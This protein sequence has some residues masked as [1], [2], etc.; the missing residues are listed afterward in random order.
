MKMRKLKDGIFNSFTIISAVIVTLLLFMIF[1]FV[2]IRGAHLINIRLLLND[3]HAKNYVVYIEDS[4]NQTF[5]IIETEDN[6]YFVPNYGISLSESKDL[7]GNAIIEVQYVSPDSPLKYLELINGETIEFTKGMSIQRIAFINEPS[8]QRSNGAQEM[9]IAL[10]NDESTLREISFSIPGGGIR[11]PLISTI[12]LI[13][14]TLFIVIPFGILSALYLNEY[15]PKNKITNTLRRFIETLSGVPSI[16]FGLVGL[17]IFVPFTTMVTKASGANLIAGALTLSAIL[18]PIVIRTTEEGFKMVPNEHRHVSLALG[19]NTFQT[20]IFIVVP[21]SLPNILTTIFLSIGRIIGESAALI[22]VLGT[23][24][25][26][27][28]SIYERTPS[29]AV[30]IWSLMTREPANVELASAIAIIILVVVLLLNIFIKASVTLL[31]RRTNDDG[32]I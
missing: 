10:N 3:F 24:I 15:A 20:S 17:S 7:A 13:G 5:D 29:L 2:I 18:L 6:E 12:Y 9:A 32:N 8:V 4:F 16:V 21:G 23:A 25:R 1:L 11:A 14:L 30:Q 22:F 27:S 19:A 26:D 31:K 28:V